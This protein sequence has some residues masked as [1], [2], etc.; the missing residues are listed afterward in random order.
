VESLDRVRDIW[1]EAF[2]RSIGR[3]DEQLDALRIESAFIKYER[4]GTKWP[5]PAQIIELM[6]R[7]VVLNQLPEPRQEL[8][9]EFKQIVDGLCNDKF[10]RTFWYQMLVKMK[11]ENP[12]ANF[13]PEDYLFM[14]RKQEKI[15]P[16]DMEAP[17]GTGVGY[18]L[19]GMV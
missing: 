14:L 8:P 1:V 17:V 9:K 3:I 16:I 7:R 6:P 15:R 13:D 11:Q 5:S 4:T 18:I 19:D 12:G 10:S 2:M